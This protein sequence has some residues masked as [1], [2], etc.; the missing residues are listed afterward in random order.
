MTETSGMPTISSDARELLDRMLAAGP[1]GL[2]TDVDGTLSPIAPTPDAAILLS[3]AREALQAVRARFELVVAVSGRSALDA[4]RMVGLN[5]ITYLGNHGFE[6]LDPGAT[7]PVIWPDAAPYQDDVNAVLD[8]IEQQASPRFPGLRVERKG[9]TGSI[10]VRMCADPVEAEDAVR[11][12]LSILAVQR[13]LRVTRGRMVIE[14]RPPVEMDKGIAVAEI[15]R[16]AG[17]RG[18]L[19]IGDDRTDMD[20][21]RIMRE[22]RE[23]D[24]CESVAVAVLHNEAPEELAEAADITLPGVE[25]V[26]GFLRTLA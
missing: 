20:A 3:G 5:D 25:S 13:G 15:V 24:E 11:R 8:D 21:F 18:A 6:R 10:H 17:L 23:S 19:Y 2:F 12:A 9:I 16:S 26:P 14:L 7:Q 4:Q 22:L 1:R